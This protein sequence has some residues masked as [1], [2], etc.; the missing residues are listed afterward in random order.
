[1]KS[2]IDYIRAH[3]DDALREWCEYLKIPSI[4]ANPQYHPQCDQAANYLADKLKAIGM[5]NVH[6]VT[7]YGRPNVC[8]DWL[9]APG[10][11]TILIYGHYDVQPPDPLELWESP[12]FE[13]TIRDNI[14]FARGADDNKGQHWP[15]VRALEAWLATEKKLPVNVKFVAEGEE[16]CGGKAIHDCMMKKEF[17]EA[18]KCDAVAIS[19]TSWP[20]HDLPGIDVGMRGLSYFELEVRGA[21]MDLHSGQYG[22]AAPNPM[23]VVAHTIAKIQNE[24]GFIQI[25]GFYDDVRKPSAAELAMIQQLPNTEDTFKK[26]I[27]VAETAGETE[28]PYMER[29]WVRPSFDV[30]GI[31]GG[32]QQPGAKTVIPSVA[33]AK[34]SFR[35]V[36]NQDGAKIKVQ[37]ESYLKSIMPRSVTWTL[38]E[39]GE[40]GYPLMV[41]TDNLYLKALGPV[42]ETVCG[43]A[44]IYTRMGASIPVATL[45]ARTWNVPVLFMGLGWHDDLLHSPNEHFPLKQFYSGM[46]LA[47]HA[48]EAWGKMSK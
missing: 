1:M 37:L 12:P 27:G 36:P 43:K 30:H 14:L 26:E 46:E 39:L 24:K 31:V 20:A 29:I 45:F 33:T 4:S 47:A 25:P 17:I 18:W 8:A 42:Y 23:K 9:H 10:K 35:L 7:G 21:K 19:D 28:F 38:R 5:E 48:L 15:W 44:P 3:K 22:G 11:P 32:Y 34:F 40:S 16:E 41:S 2:V 6:L 13:P